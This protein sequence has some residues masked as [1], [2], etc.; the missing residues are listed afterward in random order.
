MSENLNFPI[1]N[2]V[3]EPYI[4]QAVS[5]S[6]VGALGDG[7]KLIE[8]AVQDALAKKVNDQGVVDRYHNCNYNDIVTFLATKKIH[9]IAREVINGLAE[10][11][12]PSIEEKVRELILKRNDDIAHTLVNGLVDSLACKWN[13]NVELKPK[14]R[15]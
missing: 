13:I 3:L 11:M 6:I 9:E 14:S 15:D 8:L 2:N 7:T 10:Q 1:P 12:R 5:A 4:K